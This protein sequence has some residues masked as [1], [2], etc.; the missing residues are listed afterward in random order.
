ML[1]SVYRNGGFWIGQY[2]AGADSYP[3]KE[4]NSRT[5]IIAQGKYPYNYITCANAQIKSSGLN[6]GNYTSSLMFGIQWDLV[7]KHLQVRGGMTVTDLTDD[8]SSWGNYINAIF[9]IQNGEY[10]TTPGTA[11]SFKP[12][13]ENTSGKVENSKK[14]QNKSVLLTTGANASQNC[15]MNIYDI[16]GNQYEYTLEKNTDVVF[17]CTSRGGIYLINGSDTPASFRSYGSTTTNNDIYS[18]FRSALY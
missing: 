5:L 2:E 3:A 9:T 18:S 11:N 15:K 13:T 14:L 6:S 7:L 10:A 16:A 4:D 12:Y 1:S 8:S 17:P